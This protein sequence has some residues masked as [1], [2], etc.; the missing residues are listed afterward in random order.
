MLWELGKQSDAQLLQEHQFMSALQLCAWLYEHAFVL[1][2][3]AGQSA[4]INSHAN[5]H[6]NSQQPSHA[7]D[8]RMSN[9]VHLQSLSK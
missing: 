8:P 2:D 7:V 4:R 6:V 5:G 9:N 1:S 3:F